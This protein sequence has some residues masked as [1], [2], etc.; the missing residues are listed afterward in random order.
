M[1]HVE[2][3]ATGRVTFDDGNG[4]GQ[5]VTMVALVM[6]AAAAVFPSSSQWVLAAGVPRG[7]QGYL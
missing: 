6:T 1:Q 5:L 3:L 2:F 7:E 4:D